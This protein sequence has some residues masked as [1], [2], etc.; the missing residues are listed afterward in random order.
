[1]ADFRKNRIW[2][3]IIKEVRQPMLH[4]HIPIIE[5]EFVGEGQHALYRVYGRAAARQE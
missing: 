3:H 1:M 5:N 4:L 2:D